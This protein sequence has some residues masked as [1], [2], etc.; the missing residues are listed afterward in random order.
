[1]SAYPTI[2]QFNEAVQ[3]PS[4]AF[5][6]TILRS[7]KVRTNGFGYPIAL[8][9]GFALTYTVEAGGHR[10]A[11]RCFHKSTNGLEGRYARISQSLGSIG[12]PYFVGFEYQPEGVR[13]N[14]R[15][16][17]IV[18]MDWASGETLGAFIE[19]RYR[20]AAAIGKLITAFRDLEAFL[21]SKGVAHGDLQNGN[22]LVNGSLKLIDY[23]GMYVPG[24]PVGQGTEIGQKHFQ[25]PRRSAADFGPTMDRFSFIAIDLSLRALKERPDLFQRF[26]NGENIILTASDYADPAASEAFAQ[27]RGISTLARDTDNL[28]QI[29]AAVPSAV[30]TLEDFLAGRSI[31]AKI[32]SLTRP[33]GVAAPVAAVYIGAYPVV[34]ATDFGGVLRAVGD[35]VEMIGR[36]VEVKVDRTKYGRPYVFLNFGHWKGRVAKV[37]IWSDGLKKLAQAPDA[38]WV[39][40][41][42][43]VT[44]LVDPPFENKKHGYTHLSITLTEANQL[45]V[46]DEGEAKRRLASRG[47]AVNP[48]VGTGSANQDVL[49]R[50]GVQPT[51]APRPSSTKPTPAGSP[52]A[53]ASA[54]QK[55]SSGRGTPQMTPNEAILAS[56]SGSARKTASG[57]GTGPRSSSPRVTLP[58]PTYQPPPPKGSGIPSWIWWIGIG[59]LILL[60]GAR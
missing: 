9:G 13:V 35:R 6:D 18:K 36:I 23:D 25:H 54:Q 46:I 40:K 21:R 29:C 59:I 47:K 19:A 43:S 55:L 28:A 48:G 57:P 11:V 26:S 10:Y 52:V 45:R 49:S 3:N 31:P 56:L 27:L 41:W 39:G 5:T 42:I 32:I 12:K 33:A 22:V 53:V 44:G 24:L 14:G 16:L 38:S 30:P 58:P 8:G 1:M 2:D 4:T 15:G 17:P 51:G 20:D 7:G 34:D 50:L 37:N 60:M